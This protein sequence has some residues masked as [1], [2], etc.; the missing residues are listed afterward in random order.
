MDTELDD[1]R[2]LIERAGKAVGSEYKLAKAMGIPQQHL[3]AW[4]AGTRACVPADRARLAGFA[5]E[6]ALKELVR[7]TIA[8]N[9]GTVRG[10]HLRQLLGGSLRGIGAGILGGLA[11]V[12]SL[13][14]SPPAAASEPARCD[15]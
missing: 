8:A 2:G 12:L 1:L 10:T 11:L 15:V 4:K 7:A 3:S 13:I 5:K 14:S 6:D 9:D